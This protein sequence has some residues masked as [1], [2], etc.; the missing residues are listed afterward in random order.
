MVLKTKY[1]GFKS[2]SRKISTKRKTK[3][4]AFS[5][6]LAI[7]KLITTIFGP[8]HQDIPLG[9]LPALNSSIKDEGKGRERQ[10]WY[11][12][13]RTKPFKR[14]VCRIPFFAK[15]TYGIDRTLSVKVLAKHI[16]WY[17]EL[18]NGKGSTHAVKLLKRVRDACVRFAADQK[19]ELINELSLGSEG[20]PLRVGHLI[21]LLTSKTLNHRRF[22]IQVL[23]IIKLCEVPGDEPSI[24]SIV[25]PMRDA[26]KEI[27]NAVG[28]CLRALG[29]TKVDKN[30]LNAILDSF[31]SVLR[32]LF[33]VQKQKLRLTQLSH[34]SDIHMSVRKGPNGPA[35]GCIEEDFLG[36]VDSG[37][38]DPISEVALQTQNKSLQIILNEMKAELSESPFLSD[39]KARC[40]DSRLAVKYEPW[41]KTRYFAICDWFSQSALKGLHK[42]IFGWLEKQPEDGTMSQDL[43]ADIVKQWTSI[44]PYQHISKDIYSLDLSKATDR[45]PAVLQREIISQMFGKSFADNWFTICTKRSFQTPDKKRVSFVVGQPLGVYSSWAMLA[46]THHV[47]C[48]TAL[49][50]SNIKRNKESPHYVVIGDDVAMVGSEMQRWYS[51]IMNNILQVD[52]SP[53][54]GFTPSTMLGS[55]TLKQLDKSSSAEIAK[56]I[57]IDGEEL[58][59]VS[60]ETLKSSWEY[61]ADFPNLLRQ[62]TNRGVAYEQQTPVAPFALASMGYKPTLACIFATF[63]LRPCVSKE[64]FEVAW[65]SFP[66]LLDHIAWY[67][68]DVPIT[69]LELETMFRWSI[70]SGLQ[71]TLN[72]FKDH[73]NIY[74]ELSR[75]PKQRGDRM[76]H[77][78]TREYV[79]RTLLNRA[80]LYILSLV[81]QTDV[82]NFQGSGRKLDEIAGALNTMQDFHQSLM[83]KPLKPKE[84]IHRLRSRVITKLQPLVLKSV[85]KARANYGI[86]L[87]D[88][89]EQINFE[90]S[91]LTDI[92]YQNYE[93][94]ELLSNEENKT[95][96]DEAFA[97][98]VDLVERRTMEV[99][100]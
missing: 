56:R 75:K 86:L 80:V 26:P 16:N 99:S 91:S 49:K 82:L 97:S 100:T 25:N 54:K 5:K 47:I 37:L 73:F 53:I 70:R 74:I 61:P 50:L 12:I 1:N 42:W 7:V 18:V 2:N 55:N 67:Q 89:G 33:P 64:T 28:G 36:I 23:D 87:L 71:S 78:K 14:F 68:A 92:H 48:R 84:N 66:A 93:T 43:V 62:L 8:I 17:E 21:P 35:I 32:E 81:V 60:P 85:Q 95:L 94:R 77:L 44:P 11:R 39:A 13:W 3:R 51:L 83:G 96:H 58:S 76:Y 46:L 79:V 10:K 65:G 88:S 52:I 38:I 15:V 4:R 31:R 98:V 63:P 57:F 24:E 22:A 59:V 90:P 72:K 45:L 30:T 41:C 40:I 34:L 69:E 27:N 20:L 6:D 9:A 19:F 29:E